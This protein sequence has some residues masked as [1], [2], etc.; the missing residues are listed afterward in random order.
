M[1]LL[2]IADDFTGSLDTGVQLSKNNISTYITVDADHIPDCLPDCEAIV[3][4]ANIR[5]TTP[6]SAFETIFAILNK[7][8]YEGLNVYIKTD[9]VFRGNI[10]AAFAAS[11]KFINK[12]LYFIP[13][14]PEL[15]RT[16]KNSFAY[17]DGELLEKS[18]FS[19]D[20]RT[21]TNSSDISSIIN[22]NYNLNVQCINYNNLKDIKKSDIKNN[23]IYLFD[24]EN[25]EQLIEIGNI[26]DEL[27]G[28]L[29]SAGCAGF[30]STFP[31]HIEFKHSE[32][33]LQKQT[34]DKPL[35]FIS[36]S[37]NAITFKQ[38]KY[39]EKCSFPVFCL[40]EQLNTY[41]NTTNIDNAQEFIDDLTFQKLVEETSINLHNNTS[42][43][44]ATATE[45]NELL[46]FDLLY[47][48][49]KNDEQIHNYIA[50]YT[51]NLV[52]SILERV[53]LTNI[54]IFGGDMVAAILQKLEIYEVRAGGEIIAGVPI[55]QAVKDGK[56]INFVTK[57]GGFGSDNLIPIIQNYFMKG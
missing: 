21:P 1:K 22:K 29:F 37:A 48:K 47:K 18:V 38:L 12:P 34:N 31:S 8:Y 14:Y 2:I 43:I 17:V 49:G 10:S 13:A 36:G 19:N 45:K 41:I 23:N 32:S 51:S 33:I 52:K 42:V 56:Q 40:S 46:N 39:A 15:G 25:N 50:E 20:P 55:C 11:M 35:L 5:H 4:N 26:V 30:A 6:K 7:L 3:I 53:P 24:C 28:Y 9:S 57:S 16:T 27:N 44:L 54:V